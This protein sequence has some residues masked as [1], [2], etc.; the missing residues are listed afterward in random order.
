MSQ[1][2]KPSGLRQPS[3]I[4]RPPAETRLKPP[5]AGATAAIKPQGQLKPPSSKLTRPTSSSGPRSPST[6]KKETTPSPVLARDSGTTSSASRSTSLAIGDRVVVGGAKSGTLRFLGPTHFAKGEWA[7]IELEEA[8][9]KNDGSI[10]GT[11]YFTCQPSYGIFARPEKLEKAKT[12]EEPKKSVLKSNPIAM[13][14]PM[15][16]GKGSAAAAAAASAS[17]ADLQIGDRVL[18]GGVK[19]GVLRF[20]GPTEFSKGVWAGVELEEPIGKNDGSV[21]GK[22][23]DGV[24]LVPLFLNDFLCLGILSVRLCLDCSLRSIGSRRLQGPLTRRLL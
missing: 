3:K 16:A 24:F 15:P 5:S 6:A 2:P 1:L 13:S 8:Q 7:G 4:A 9:G 14:T 12:K 22:R 18:V 17:V 20:L 10:G 11:R 21:A 23:C 19:N